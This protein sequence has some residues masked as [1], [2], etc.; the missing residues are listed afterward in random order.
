MSIAVIE[1]VAKTGSGGQPAS[2]AGRRIDADPVKDPDLVKDPDVVKDPVWYRVC[3]LSDLDE[4]WGEA[5]LV[6]G[7]HVALFRTGGSQVFAVAHEYPATA[8]HLM[9]RRIVGSRGTRPT[10]A[11]PLHKEVYDLRTGECFGIPTLRLAT[12]STRLVN[13]F[14][15]IRV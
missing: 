14:V 15:E 11:S 8:A 3:P 5:A 4:S 9:A 10:I 2:Y 7:S 6:D 12:Y 13:G 1:A